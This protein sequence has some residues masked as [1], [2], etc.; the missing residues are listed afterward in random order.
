MFKSRRGQAG[1][2]SFLH[3]WKKPSAK[4]GRVVGKEGEQKS[5]GRAKRF[6]E[7]GDA[8]D[9]DRKRNDGET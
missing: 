3:G 9:L 1:F 2:V 7:R 5:E 8:T 4:S 6:I